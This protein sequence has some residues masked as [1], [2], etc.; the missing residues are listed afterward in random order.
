MYLIEFPTEILLL[1]GQILVS[2]RDAAY[3]NEV[4]G[5]NALAQ[6]CSRF[7]QILNPYLYRFNAHQQDSSALVWA[8]L[9]GDR[10]TAE[11]SLDNGADVNLIVLERS[12]VLSNTKTRQPGLQM[13]HFARLSPLATKPTLVS[14]GLLAL[15]FNRRATRALAFGSAVGGEIIPC[16][17]I[18][19]KY[20]QVIELLIGRGIDTERT[21]VGNE[22]LDFFHK[23]MTLLHRAAGMADDTVVRLLIEGGANIHAR[24]T[25]S[26]HTP[27]HLASRTEEFDFDTVDAVNAHRQDR[28]SKKQRIVRLLL[29]NG[30]DVNAR[31]YEG[32][33]SPLH[34]A[35]NS[36]ALTQILLKYGADPTAKDKHGR[37]PLH[38][39]AVVPPYGPDHRDMK[40]VGRSAW[41]PDMKTVI[42]LLIECGADIEATA[43]TGFTPLHYAA[44]LAQVDAAQVLLES[45]ANIEAT[46]KGE[47]CNS[48]MWTPLRHAIHTYVAKDCQLTR[49]RSCT[50]VT[51]LA[52]AG[53]NVNA[54]GGDGL[55]PL[56]HAAM[57][58]IIDIVR[59]LVRFGADVEA[60]DCQDTTPLQYAIYG[61]NGTISR[62]MENRPATP[63]SG[64][65]RYRT[66]PAYAA[67]VEYLS[68]L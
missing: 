42:R 60:R 1:L 26:Q 3:R 4:S 28:R 44:K 29:E 9:R 57:Y 68:S 27:L 54:K 24:T 65:L 23:G 43:K 36:P 61:R 47:V 22:R 63:A 35:V 51:M 34:F 52:K 62:E 32:D 10:R 46:D 14:S 37:T 30:A 58:G 55:T 11:L 66:Q 31:C 12:G 50:L 25:N 8:T 17:R 67:T 13:G 15:V 45:G 19:A 7:Y 6:T 38:Q 49:S 39:A 64:R 48:P 21:D 20:D 40:W 18:R 33:T 41:R 53:A 59:I 2:E 16:P 56:H 5:L